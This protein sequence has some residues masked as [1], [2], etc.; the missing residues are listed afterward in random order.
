MEEEVMNVVVRGIS[1]QGSVELVDQAEPLWSTVKFKIARPLSTRAFRIGDQTKLERKNL[2][3]WSGDVAAI[4][5]DGADFWTYL[6]IRVPSAKG[7]FS[8]FL[9]LYVLALVRVL[10]RICDSVI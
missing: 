4:E 6:R 10:A 2:G 7:H 9:F 8:W 5:D 1:Y 3:S